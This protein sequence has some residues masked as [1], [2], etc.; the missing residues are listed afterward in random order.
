MQRNVKIARTRNRKFMRTAILL[1]AWATTGM[2]AAAQQSAPQQRVDLDQA[3]QL[4]LA[5]NHALKAAQ[6]Q[7]PQ[8]EAEEITAAIHPNPVFSYDDL[9]VPLF[10][11]SQLNTSTLDNITEFDLGL[12]LHL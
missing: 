6:S 9:Y 2:V 4:A 12:Q 8:S 5:H 7:V 11:P 1:L 3:I 10:S